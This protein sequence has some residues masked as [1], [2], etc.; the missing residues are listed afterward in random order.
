M[1][2]TREAVI[3]KCNEKKGMTCSPKKCNLCQ[4]SLCYLEHI[5]SDDGNRPQAGHLKAILSAEPPRTRKSLQSLIGTMN[6]LHEYVPHYSELIAPMTDL[7]SPQRAYKWTLEAQEALDA[8]KEAFRSHK[9]LSRPDTT[10]PFILQTG[11]SGKGMG[12]VFMQQGPDRNRRII[13]HSSA[14]FSPT[15]ARYYCNEQ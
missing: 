9:P 3:E 6:W 11:A 13:S 14:K 7:L 2:D 15:E 10:L 5:V 1:G 8:V 12:A 4:T